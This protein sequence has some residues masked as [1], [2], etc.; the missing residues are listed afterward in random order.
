MWYPSEQ[1]NRHCF[2]GGTMPGP[3]DGIKVFEVSQIVAGPYCGLNLADLGADVVKVEPPGGEGSRQSGGFIPGE[4]KGFHSL[5]RGKRSLVIDLG[6]P[7]AQALVHRIIPD[8]ETFGINP[9]P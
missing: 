2:R 8:V 4:S 3:L 9:R 1:A 7:D 6:S 5:N